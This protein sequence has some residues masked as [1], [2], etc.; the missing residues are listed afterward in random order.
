MRTNQIKSNE[1]TTVDH[2]LGNKMVN[3]GRMINTVSGIFEIINRL[4][5]IPKTKKPLDMYEEMVEICQIWKMDTEGQQLSPIMMPTDIL[6]RFVKHEHET[7]EN[8]GDL[9]KKHM[10]KEMGRSNTGV[11]LIV[12]KPMLECHEE[13]VTSPNDLNGLKHPIKSLLKFFASHFYASTRSIYT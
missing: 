1:D 4:L 7:K 13:V 9:A 10:I 2:T 12:V 6:D 3:V 8:A 5:S 11:C